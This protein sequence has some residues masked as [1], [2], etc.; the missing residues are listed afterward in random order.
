MLVASIPP[1]SRSLELLN[2]S[3][4]SMFLPIVDQ[5]FRLVRDEHRQCP[6]RACESGSSETFT[7]FSA[8]VSTTITELPALQS[9]NQ[10]GPDSHLLIHPHHEAADLQTC[11]GE[12]DV[13]SPG[14]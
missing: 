6:Q 11:I 14:A 13:M 12:L 1:L 5:D 3:L 9:K 7:P 8:S 4:R 2:W 10:P